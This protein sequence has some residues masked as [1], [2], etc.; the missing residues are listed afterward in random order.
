MPQTG[1]HWLSE[2]W[3]SRELVFFLALR[4]IKLR[5]R[6]TLLGVA[7]AA[8]QPLLTMILFTF[9]FGRMAKIPTE[10][11][12]APFFYFSA[13]VPWTYFSAAVGQAGT[14]IVGN[15]N[16]VT[17]VYFPR[18]C[19][20]IAAV[21]GGLVDFGIAS[22]LMC[23]MMIYYGIV[24]TWKMA[25]W[26]PTVLLLVLC[27][28]ALAIFLSALNVRYRDVKHAVPFVLQLWL[29]ATPIIYPQ[30]LIPERLRSLVRLNPLTGIIETI[31][32]A[33][34]PGLAVDWASLALS[35]GIVILGLVLSVRYFNRAE[36]V[37]TDVI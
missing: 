36:Q 34:A 16:L 33:Y 32:A 22:L 30:S 13:L 3:R 28:S 17:K 29:F 6:Q 26:L 4:D 19:L 8:L 20:P 11:L 2:L 31:R 37:F 15:A 12:P 24:P 25:L 14:S 35:S 1:E 9:V 10:G 5:Y 27:T 23:G 21:V 18:L 7:W